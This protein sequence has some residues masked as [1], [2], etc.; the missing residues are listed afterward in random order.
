MI[1]VFFSFAVVLILILILI[2][3]LLVVE[4]AVVLSILGAVLAAR[5]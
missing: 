3:V 2:L 5:R 1:L 4:A